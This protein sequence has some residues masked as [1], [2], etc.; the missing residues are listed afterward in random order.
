MQ[1]NEHRVFSI[2][3]VT[4]PVQEVSVSRIFIQRAEAAEPQLT[5]GTKLPEKEIALDTKTE[6]K[7]GPLD[8]A[9]DTHA[10]GDTKCACVMNEIF[11]HDSGWA[12][13]GVGKR[14]K[15]PCNMRVPSSWTPAVGKPS[16]EYSVNGVFAKFA[17][18]ED[19][20]SACTELYAR[21]YKDLSA[22]VL[23]SRWTDGGGNAAYRGGVK[24]CYN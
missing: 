7:K 13:A 19:G 18:L 23:V 20:I 5:F 24:N 17:T 10:P 14:A 9:C 16:K 21:R 22:S 2:G 1:R 11:K 8:V 6:K 4:R 15:N 12:T 3:Q